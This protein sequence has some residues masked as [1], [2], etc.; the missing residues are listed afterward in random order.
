MIQTVDFGQLSNSLVTPDSP[1]TQEIQRTDKLVDEL[2]KKLRGNPSLVAN[3]KKRK[4]K[5]DEATEQETADS[6]I[7]QYLQKSRKT[8]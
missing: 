5:T 8:S 6:I 4:R 7:R 3:A 2:Y 1:V